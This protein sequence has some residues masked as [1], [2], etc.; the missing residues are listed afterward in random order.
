M[1]DIS[2]ILRNKTIYTL[3]T[4]R[5]LEITFNLLNTFHATGVS[6]RQVKRLWT[7]SRNLFSYF[8][9]TCSMWNELFWLYTKY[10]GRQSPP[11]PTLCIKCPPSRIGQKCKYF[12]KWTAMSKSHVCVRFGPVLCLFECQ[13]SKSNIF[14]DC[15]FQCFLL[16]FF[17]Y[18]VFSLLELM[19][20]T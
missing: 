19:V 17:C 18:F 11:P 5:G 20:S 6:I 4:T 12:R 15:L 14:V 1:P 10:H 16:S 13:A 9:N 3:S 2:N 7:F 8:F